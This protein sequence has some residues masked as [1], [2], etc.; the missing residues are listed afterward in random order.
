MSEGQDD[1][2]MAAGKAGRTP[3]SE[4]I[5]RVFESLRNAVLDQR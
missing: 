2:R 4:E 3:S 1:G 5:Q